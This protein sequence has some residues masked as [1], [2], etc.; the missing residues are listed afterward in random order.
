MKKL[1]L[2]LALFTAVLFASCNKQQPV[3]VEEQPT[4]VIVPT[5]SPQV[6]DSTLLESDITLDTVESVK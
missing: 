1:Q 3:T 4:E 6:P 5:P 2:S